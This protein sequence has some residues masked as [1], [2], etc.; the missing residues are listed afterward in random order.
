MY[1][2]HESGYLA[3]SPAVEQDKKEIRDFSKEFFPQERSKLA[4]ELLYL[5]RKYRK[6]IP[7]E[8]EQKRIK[9]EQALEELDKIKV[10]ADIIDKEFQ[11]TEEMKE[12][13]EE[14]K[15]ELTEISDEIEKRKQS[16]V[17]KM[18]GRTR[19]EELNKKQEET[20]RKIDEISRALGRNINI[21]SQKEQAE[22]RLGYYQQEFE[23]VVRDTEETIIDESWND[24]LKQK[25]D[26]FYSQQTEGKEDWE[27]SERRNVEVQ[28][29]DRNMIFAHGI[30]MEQDVFNSGKNE[31]TSQKILSFEE[32]IIIATS[33][34]PAL[35]VSSK[36]LNE[37]VAEN[38]KNKLAFPSGLLLGG[39]KLMMVFKNDESTISL[40]YDLKQTKHKGERL[41]LDVDEKLDEL[42]N[43]SGSNYIADRYNEVVIKRPNM[44]AVYVSVDKIDDEIPIERLEELKKVSS[45]LNIPIVKI[46]SDGKMRNIET[47]ENVTV[48]ELISKKRNLSARERVELINSVYEDELKGDGELPENI[49]NRLR[50]LEKEEKKV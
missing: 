9:R 14:L 7:E 15:L 45:K 27:N 20:Q 6:D 25:I 21:E 33:L 8:N 10:E 42:E 38:Y 23:E 31:I 30:P 3:T 49:E 16:L 11:K 17:K 41:H 34:E 1:L 28:S 50:E 46:S 24:L 44:C 4:H 2:D 36:K 13:L 37:E 40:N 47:N 48:A 29:V 32:R 43:Y 39:G 22:K 12:L 35:S 5:R 19:T 26:N 18:F